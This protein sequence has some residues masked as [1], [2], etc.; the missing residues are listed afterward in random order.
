MGTTRRLGLP[1]PAMIVAVLGLVAALGGTAVAQQAT[2]SAKVTKKKVKKIADKEIQ[3]AAPGLSV[4]NAEKANT[5]TTATTATT[6]GSADNVLWAVVSNGAGANDAAIARAG[7]SGYAVSESG[8]PSVIVDF[9]RNVTQCAW[10]A[11]KG[12]TGNGIATAQAATTEGVAA[13]P[14]A[15]QVRVRNA[16]GTAV[17][18]SFH[19]EV[20]C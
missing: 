7:K 5:A 12:S 9:Q 2:T 1:S 13:N 16:T 17:Q 15:V 18:E 4:A 11:T 19:V 20:I 8:G 3:K 6:A 10:M 14:E